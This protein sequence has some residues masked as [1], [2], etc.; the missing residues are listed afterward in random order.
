[1]YRI[2]CIQDVLNEGDYLIVE[3]EWILFV[4][5]SFFEVDFFVCIVDVL[6]K[7]DQGE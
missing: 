4:S 2:E 5:E 7:W 3:E 6:E 1:M